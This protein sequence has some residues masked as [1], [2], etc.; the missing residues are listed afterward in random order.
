MQQNFFSIAEFPKIKSEFGDRKVCFY[1]TDTFYS[2]RLLFKVQHVTDHSE[3]YTQH[4]QTLKALNCFESQT[5]MSQDA[6]LLQEL[7]QA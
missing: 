5:L 4:Y 3:C 6:M 1:L 7:L 2:L